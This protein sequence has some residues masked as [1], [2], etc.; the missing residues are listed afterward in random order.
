MVTPKST[1]EFQ[2]AYARLNTAQK[3]AV[4]TI[5]GPVM[6]IAGPGTGKTQVLT[7]RIANILL[8]TDTPPD[9][10]LALTFT[11]AGVYAM[12]TRLASLIGPTA[13]SVKIHTFHSFCNALIQEHPSYFKRLVGAE[14]ILPI[15]AIITARG[16]IDT[17][18]WDHLTSFGDRYVHVKDIIRTISQ[19]K[20]EYISPQLLRERAELEVHQIQSSGETYHTSGRY[21]GE[22]KGEHKKQLD[23][24]SRTLELADAFERYEAALRAQKTY[25]FDDMIIEVLRVFEENA[26]FLQ[27]VQEEY[28]Y[29][30]ADEHQ[31]ANTSQNTLL[32]LLS[33]FHESPNLFLVG[34]EKQAIYSFQGASLEHFHTFKRQYPHAEMITLTDSYRS[35]T[36][37]LA[38]SREL[39]ST[40]VAPER[41]PEL[42]SRHPEPHLATVATR[43]FST[44]EHELAWVAADIKEKLGHG[45]EPT[46]IAV[47]FRNNKDA[48]AL[49]RAL[50]AQE[51]PH[52]VET[53]QNALE[54]HRVQQLITWMKASADNYSD[55]AMAESL[56]APWSGLE[57]ADIHRIVRAVRLAREPFFDVLKHHEKIEGLRDR[58]AVAAFVSRMKRGS[59]IAREDHARDFFSYCVHDSGFLRFVLTHQGTADVLA[60]VRGMLATLE[61]HARKEVGYSAQRFLIDIGLYDMYGV[62][63]DKDMPMPST[64]QSV[65]LMTAHAS[66]G[67]EFSYVYIIHAR[68]KKW[69]NARGRTAFYIPQ[70]EKSDD[71]DERRIMYVALTRAK[72]GAFIS[73]AQVTQEGGEALPSLFIESLGTHATVSSVSEFESAYAPHSLL[74]RKAT[75]LPGEDVAF[76]KALF[77]E[78]GL[79]VTALN[80]YL[81]CPWR[82]FYRNLVRIPDVT[83]NH[84]LF[85]NGMHD[86]LKEF[87]DMY[88]ESG[89]LPALKYLLAAVHAHLEKQG[90]DAAGLAEA[91]KKADDAIPGWFAERKDTFGE[92]KIFSELPLECDLHIGTP[93]MQRILLRGKIDRLDVFPDGS[94]RV[95]DY[96]TGKPKTRNEILGLTKNG[97]GDYHRQLVFYKLCMDMQK[98]GNLREACIDFLEPHSNGSYRLESF[99][100][101]DDDVTA[102]T[103]TI[104]RAAEEI[105]TLTFWDGG[106]KQKDCEYCALRAGMAQI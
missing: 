61:R 9:A 19:L 41:N 11:E 66:K 43:T 21:K 49:T 99:T 97:T 4:D 48:D 10:I 15:D 92:A 82:Y 26:D 22:M 40:A 23:R 63:I 14:P 35:G 100:V 38:A 31:D 77:V 46:E 34:D 2:K 98:K 58:E 45:V 1:P 93:S 73:H 95:T 37:I 12:K 17:R 78:Q 89:K 85:G 64:L 29:I 101:T 72:L 56:F 91:K 8:S 24:L 71:D 80:N 30:L 42:I 44:E 50:A 28:L 105:Y 86:G 18:E 83:N 5:E 94:I 32:T 47:L 6:V 51:V 74:E 53:H 33:S 106:C 84:L 59:E 88:T 102:L 7:L 39:M 79:S 67:L 87:F 76:L 25:D 54:H 104:A 65:H 60:R 69:G 96:K 81:E 70:L 36:Q 68:D 20:R 52:I 13:Y 16:V 75:A 62:A 3:K 90:F 103:A 27:M 57:E 55:R